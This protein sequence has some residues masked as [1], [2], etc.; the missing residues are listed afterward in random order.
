MGPTA[1]QSRIYPPLPTPPTP[2]FCYS[3]ISFPCSSCGS[4]IA[5]ALVRNNVTGDGFPSPCCSCG[6]GSAV[7][8]VRQICE[9]MGEIFELRTYERFTSLEV[10][11]GGLGLDGYAEVQ[12]GDCVVAFSRKDIY[13]IKQVR[14]WRFMPIFSHS[15]LVAQ[16]HPRH[17]EQVRLPALCTMASAVPFVN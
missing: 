12:P 13:A 16:G 1:E 10:E 8:L 11:A 5:A 7:A 4:G 15:F 3:L 14:L 2:L 6:D 17:Q 9:E